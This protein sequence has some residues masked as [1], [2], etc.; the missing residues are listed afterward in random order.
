MAGSRVQAITEV[1]DANNGT[2]QTNNTVT[3]GFPQEA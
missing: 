1:H 2:Q 3:T